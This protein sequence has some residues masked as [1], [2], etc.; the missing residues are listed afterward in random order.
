MERTDLK[1]DPFNIIITGVG[2]QGN[3]MA[4]R[5]VGN[6]L[7]GK[8][9]KVT[10]GETFGVSQRGGSVMSHLRISRKGTWSP[11]IPKG[12]ADLIVALEP[13]E[14]VR[15]L[16]DYGNA[17]TVL[18]SNTRPVYPISVISGEATYPDIDDFRNGMRTL[19]KKTILIDATE[20][21]LAMGDAILSNVIMIGATA[22]LKIV[23]LEKAA[24]KKVISRMVPP[25][26][27]DINMKAFT[28]GTHLVS[29][30]A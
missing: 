20:A 26:K 1:K 10:I 24:F 22:G 17:K 9:F 14:A 3:V 27:L 8:G 21:A 23:P 29:R 7:V 2:G 13:S 5:V 12:G 28:R 30:E 25:D 15:V 19:T 16:R 6:M 4:S 18:L 11:Q